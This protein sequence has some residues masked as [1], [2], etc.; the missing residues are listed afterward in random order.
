MLIIGDLLSGLLIFVFGGGAVGKLVRAQSQVQ[1][2]ERLRIGWQRYRLIG[3]PEAAAALGLLAGFAI[4]PL[5]AAA[6]IG[7]VLLMAGALGF[8]IRVRDSAAFLLADSLLLAL[9]VTTALLRIASG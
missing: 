9:A 2:A 5:G 3:A 8:R 6:A 4:A 7:L 1:T